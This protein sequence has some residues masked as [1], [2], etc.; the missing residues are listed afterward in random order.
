MFLPPQN[1][2][3]LYEGFQGLKKV[4]QHTRISLICWKF[5]IGSFQIQH[6]GL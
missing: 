2:I 3:L 4:E 6:W 1:T 5:C